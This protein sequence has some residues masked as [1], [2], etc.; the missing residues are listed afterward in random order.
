MTRPLLAL[1]L[2][3]AP[4]LARPAL[5][6]TP[7]GHPDVVVEV[8]TNVGVLGQVFE[9]TLT[10][11]TNTTIHLPSGCLVVGVFNGSDC[12][13]AVAFGPLCTGALVPIGPGQSI[14]GGWAQ[15]DDNGQQ[16]APGDYSMWIRWWDDGFVTLFDCCAPVTIAPCTGPGESYCNAAPNSTGGPGWLC[17]DGSANI[18]NQDFTLVAGGLPAGEFGYFL[19]SRT[20][21]LSMPI[22]SSGTL[23]LT[24][25]VG[26]F[27]GPG[28][29]IT[30]PT[31]SL[32]VDLASIPVNPPVA[33][34]S[35]ET[36]RFQCW[37]RDGNTNNFTNALEV[38]FQ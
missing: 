25:N 9:V 20:A 26:R 3:A 27:N 13:G 4:L 32:Q 37:Y 24:G 8:D 7:C 19:A 15:N 34:Q 29:L 38:Q 31:G 21:G 16:V 11:N 36:W 5:A 35:G 23:C 12:T 17:A 33:V 10:N 6:Q 14:V 1:A 18:L 30:G 22:N 28:Q 2:L